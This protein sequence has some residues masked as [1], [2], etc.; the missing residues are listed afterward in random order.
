M[1]LIRETDDECVTRAVYPQVNDNV[2]VVVAENGALL[3]ASVG[4]P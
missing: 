4:R 2:V 1:I 3:A